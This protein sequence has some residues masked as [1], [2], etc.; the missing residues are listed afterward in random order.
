MKKKS[1]TKKTQTFGKE[2][3]AVSPH[4]R[5]GNARS[6]ANKTGEDGSKGVSG[7]QL[8]VLHRKEANPGCYPQQRLPQWFPDCEG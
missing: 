7:V 5:H 1:G 6:L 3:Q 2:C 4:F 8:G